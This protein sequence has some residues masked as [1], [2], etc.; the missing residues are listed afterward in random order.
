[1]VVELDTDRMCHSRYKGD[2]RRLVVI[3]KRVVV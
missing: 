3:F 2:N 1:M